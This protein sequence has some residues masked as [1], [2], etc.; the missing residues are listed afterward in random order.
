MIIFFSLRTQ[1]ETKEM[2]EKT[3][4]LFCT[5]LTCQNQSRINWFIVIK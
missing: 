2:Q 5:I 1:E 4:N 3:P